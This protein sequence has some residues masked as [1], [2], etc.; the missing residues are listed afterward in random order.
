[1]NRARWLYHPI[2]I[3]ILSLIALAISLFLYIYWYVSVSAG[4][5]SLSL[6]YHLDPNQFLEAKTWV[7]ILVLSLLVGV[8]LTGILTIFIYNLK[9]LHLYR[10][11][12]TF[13]SNFTHELK[14]PVTSLK[15]YLE[16]FD[17]HKIPRDDQLK[18]IS[19]MLQDVER[20]S[21]PLTAS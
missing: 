20:L 2:F 21:A 5:K 19:F 8:I 11:Q 6:R 10:L 18:Y 12:H 7:V 17:K 16:T 14:T 13:I 15:L 9:T 3:F 1:M 4:L